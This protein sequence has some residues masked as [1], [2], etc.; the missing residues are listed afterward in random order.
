MRRALE[1]G[2]REASAV[3]DHV[4]QHLD[5]AFR[6][7]E[8]AWREEPSL[9]YLVR[10]R[11]WEYRKGKLVFLLKRAL[12]NGLFLEG[13]N[14]HRSFRTGA[15]RW[16]LPTAPGKRGFNPHRSF[17]TGA[18][19]PSMISLLDVRTNPFCADQA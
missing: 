12:E 6:E 19:P 17:R 8:A 16:R 13:F 2:K 14:P 5:E 4:A 10:Q 9:S 15:T 3:K 1:A 11:A 18:T 7:V